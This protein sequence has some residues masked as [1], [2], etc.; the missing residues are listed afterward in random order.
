MNKVIS[1]FIVLLF[2]SVCVGAFTTEIIG[3]L[4]AKELFEQLEEKDTEW[5]IINET[6]DLIIKER[7]IC[8]RVI[9]EEKKDN[10]IRTSTSQSFDY[11]CGYTGEWSDCEYGISGGSHT[12]CYETQEQKSFW[13]L[14]KYC[15]PGWVLV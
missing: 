13:W 8:M 1:L 2:Y 7:Y 10:V 4:S 9:S 15:K 12:R 3:Q 11:Y 6:E 5:S 14:G